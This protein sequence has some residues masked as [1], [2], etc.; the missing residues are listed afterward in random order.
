MM[1]LHQIIK[2]LRERQMQVRQK[3]YQPHRSI[4]CGETEL[5]IRFSGLSKIA[6]LYAGVSIP[7]QDIENVEVGAVE[8]ISIFAP[9]MG[10]SNPLSGARAGRFRVKGEHILAAYDNPAHDILIL[11]LRSNNRSTFDK[12]VIEIDNSKQIEKQLKD[13]I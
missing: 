6:A 5:S 9:R 12:V 11:T 4:Q 3:I 1:K 2:E 7:Y 13:K 8:E 10:Y